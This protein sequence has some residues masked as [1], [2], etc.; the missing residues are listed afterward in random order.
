MEW[1]DCPPMFAICYRE[2]L[3]LSLPKKFAIV[4]MTTMMEVVGLLPSFFSF[5][6]LFVLFESPL[7]EINGG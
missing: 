6:V 4:A 3:K 5:F 7:I 2:S 1:G